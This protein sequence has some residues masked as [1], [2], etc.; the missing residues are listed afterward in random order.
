MTYLLK[1]AFFSIF[2]NDQ[3]TSIV[4]FICSFKIINKLTDNLIVM[5]NK[6]L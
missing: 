5:I 6:N 3:A 4:I 2:V 1:S